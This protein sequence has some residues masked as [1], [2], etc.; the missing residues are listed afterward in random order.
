MEVNSCT[1]GSDRMW[2]GRWSPA[3]AVRVVTDK[4]NEDAQK[5][6]KSLS[7]FQNIKT[8]AFASVFLL[9]DQTEC[10]ARTTYGRLPFCFP[11][12]VCVCVCVC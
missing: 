6:K 11:G 3:P 2:A 10:R 9:G 5:R 7:V 12:C 8:R 1:L 4:D